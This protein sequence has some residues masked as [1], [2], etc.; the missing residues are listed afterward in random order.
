MAYVN[1]PIPL[2]SLYEIVKNA[3]Q[4]GCKPLL[5]PGKKQIMRFTCPR[6]GGFMVK[7]T[8]PPDKRHKIHACK[9]CGYRY[10]SPGW[11]EIH[12]TFNLI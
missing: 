7:F 12:G 10:M 8:K 1:K 2:P 6:C 11:T 9:D 5:V 4:Y 3:A